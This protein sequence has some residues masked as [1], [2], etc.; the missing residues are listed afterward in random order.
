MPY[1]YTS[2]AFSGV[3]VDEPGPDV[4]VPGVDNLVKKLVERMERHTSLSGCCITYD[5]YSYLHLLVFLYDIFFKKKSEI[6]R[7][8]KS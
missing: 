4:Y 3:P 1:S 2:L 8:F 5:R 7:R 6:T